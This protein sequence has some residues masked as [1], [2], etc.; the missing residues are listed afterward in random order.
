VSDLL[1]D[2]ATSAEAPP[3]PAPAPRRHALTDP[4]RLP[5]PAL[6]ALLWALFPPVAWTAE[7]D[8]DIVVHVDKD[9]P[10]ISVYVDC[11]VTA[12]ALLV[13]SVLTDYDRMAQF[14]SNLETSVVERREDNR[15]RVHQKGKASRG[16]LTFSFDNVREIELR[17]YQEIRSQLVSGE[18]ESS[19]FTTR[20]AEID[21]VIHNVNVGRY[22]PKIWVPPVV[23]PALIAAETR[24]QFGEI[25]AEI[26]RRRSL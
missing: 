6:L 7:P 20:I 19:E 18:L 25:R 21:G 9:G 22:V 2:T 16:P 4:R 24:K 5:L 11:P 8:Q 1:I 14:V 12:P 3:P 17:P 23:G 10:T 26:L 15:L 13:W